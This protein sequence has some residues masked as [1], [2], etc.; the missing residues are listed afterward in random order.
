MIT[1]YDIMKKIEVELDTINELEQVG[2]ILELLNN[3]LD[4]LVLNEPINNN[5]KHILNKIYLAE[6]ILNEVI[7]EY[8]N[9]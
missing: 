6:G 5:E 7:N 4:K 3:L 1:K 2:F 8:Y 9:I